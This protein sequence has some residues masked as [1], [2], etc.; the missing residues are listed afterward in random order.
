M[1]ESEVT[2]TAATIASGSAAA[3]ASGGAYQGQDSRQAGR[4]RR[5]RPSTPQPS[6]PPQLD[7]PR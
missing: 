3:T 1:N 6:G 5:L 2:A 4:M 7:F